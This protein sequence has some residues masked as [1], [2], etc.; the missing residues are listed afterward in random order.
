MRE[1]LLS[2]NLK[3]LNQQY[4]FAIKELATQDLDA[5][6]K[7]FMQHLDMC[8]VIAALPVSD[9]NRVCQHVTVPLC[10][11]NKLEP[12]YL[13]ELIKIL[14]SEIVDDLSINRINIILLNGA[15]YSERC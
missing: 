15:S 3:N 10:I 5:A 13:N 11:V 4:L 2:K 1:F 12:K 7:L 8:K 14:S 6:S 9:I